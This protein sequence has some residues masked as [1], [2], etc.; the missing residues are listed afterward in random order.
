M[1]N[2]ILIGFMGSG[3][4]SVGKAIAEKMQ[5]TFIDMDEA[6]VQQQGKSINEI[7][8]ESGEAY[9]RSLETDFLRSAIESKNM[10][11]STGGGVV[12]QPDN[13]ELLHKIGK[14]VYLNTP[15]EQILHNVK[16]DTSRPLLQQ[17]NAEEI[18]FSMMQ[19]RE[20]EYFGAADIIIQTK[21]KTIH[22]IADEIIG[23]L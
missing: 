20:P 5:L 3:K 13:V 22:A 12:T 21:G 7:F 4:S 9:F 2:I 18:I 16:G 17:E 1:E 19:K 10:V 14:I 8:S 23:L 11:L 15:Y 6:I